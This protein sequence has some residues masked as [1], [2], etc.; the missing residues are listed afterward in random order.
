MTETGCV[1]A[2][3]SVTGKDIVVVPVLP[4]VTDAS[5]IETDGGPWTRNVA[6]RV[7]DVVPSLIATVTFSVLP[8]V[9][10]GTTSATRAVPPLNDS[11]CW[12]TRPAIDGSPLILPRRKGVPV[13]L[14]VTLKETVNGFPTT[15]CAGIATGL[16]ITGLPPPF[17]LL[18]KATGTSVNEMANTTPTRP[19]DTRFRLVARLP[20]RLDGLERI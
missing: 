9:F 12:T 17:R 14:R 15:G 10:A 7:A 16:A 19:P 4:S 2:A 3:E 20:A 8:A 6:T 18:L 13:S 5:P 1:L 11:V